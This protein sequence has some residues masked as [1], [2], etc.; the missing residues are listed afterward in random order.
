MKKR[1]LALIMSTTMVAAA[2]AGCGS[3]DAQTPA[4]D[5]AATTETNAVF[6]FVINWWFIINATTSNN[7]ASKG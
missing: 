3:S 2:L 6:G 1:V 5:S 4:A 7:V